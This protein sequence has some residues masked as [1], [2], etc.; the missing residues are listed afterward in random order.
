MDKRE[1]LALARIDPPKRSPTERVRDFNPISSPYDRETLILQ[2]QRCVECKNPPCMQA[3]PL[4]N[5]IKDWL[6]LT[7]QGRVSEAALCSRMTNPMPE[8]CGRIC[9]QDRLC[10]EV[11]IVG[12]KHEPVAIGAIEWNIN[13]LTF[14]DGEFP[15][16]PLP[17]P[18]G[19][20]VAV[21]GA[22]PAGLACAA[23][24]VRRGHLVTV[25]DAWLQPGG[26]L[27][28][29][30]P[31]F[32]LSRDVVDREVEMLRRLGIT[33][34]TNTRIGAHLTLDELF[35]IGFDAV[36]L[37]TGATDAKRPE[38]PGIHLDG[39]ED[40]LP[41]LIR[42]NVPAEDLPETLRG[43]DDLTGQRVAVFGGGDTAMDCVR[44]AVRLGAS[45]VRCIYRRDE[46]NMPGSRREVKSAREEGIEFL[47]LTQPVQFIGDER[48]HVRA[49][50]CIRME[51]GEPGADGRRR[52]VAI[53]ASN[54]EVEVDTAIVAFGFD[55][56]PVPD[57]RDGQLRRTKYGSYEVDA[58]LMT[59]RP[60][61]F[62]GGDIVRGADLV[63]TA[64]KDGLDAAR[65]IDEYLTVVG[66]QWSVVGRD[67]N[68]DVYE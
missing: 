50:E 36:F 4:G 34:V 63:V 42:N 3:C 23:G 25:Y 18:T 37:G 61:V 51:L 30:I 43:H 59:T 26:L 28:Y 32:K 2:A 11:C 47:F 9:P 52:P 10:E 66:G 48:G 40:A 35:E 46:A 54:F 58:T 8:I 45:E 39:I 57:Q 41:F 55:P 67:Q 65:H 21:I 53:P 38:T 15:V 16:P 1:R 27:R 60:G 12:V 7:A 49:V 44:T 31:G 64:L 14:A 6:V 33:F 5:H 24:L 29:G 17:P 56:T 22:G 68:E 62:A 19:K 20:L 13:D